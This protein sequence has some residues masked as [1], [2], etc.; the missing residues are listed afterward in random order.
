MGFKSDIN[1]IMKKI[2]MNQDGIISYHEFLNATV[3]H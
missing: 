1:K 2:D 3:D